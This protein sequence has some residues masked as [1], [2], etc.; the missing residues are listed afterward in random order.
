MYRKTA[1]AAALALAFATPAVLAAQTCLGYS[2]FANGNVQLGAG[3]T[4]GDDVSVYGA[5]IGVGAVSGGF[6]G[7]QIGRAT[8]EIE[9]ADDQSATVFGASGGWQIP[10]GTPTA[11]RTTQFCPIAGVSHLTG[12]FDED[13]ISGD[14]NET[15]FGIGGAIGVAVRSSEAFSIIPFGAVTY[16]WWSGEVDSDFLSIEGDANYAALELGV[17]FLANEWITIRPSAILPFAEDDDFEVDTRY[18][19]TFAFN[20]GGRGAR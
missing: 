14:F 6:I 17:G 15:D 4:F 8:I 1:F 13:G 5:G 19:V 18:G 11:T 2:S 20:F 7:G 3:A 12:E 10:L 9:D 16:N